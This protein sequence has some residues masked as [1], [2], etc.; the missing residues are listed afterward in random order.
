MT[1]LVDKVGQVER[2]KADKARVNKSKKGRVA[3]ID[4]EDNDL[5]SDVKYN[6]VEENEVD[7][8]N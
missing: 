5:V 8:P 4:M 2:L 1:Q 3:Y 7:W 6:H